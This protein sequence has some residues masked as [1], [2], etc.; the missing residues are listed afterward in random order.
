[1]FLRLF[2]SAVAEQWR[3]HCDAISTRRSPQLEISVQP[4]RTEIVTTDAR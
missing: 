4:D 3:V 1:M 2:F